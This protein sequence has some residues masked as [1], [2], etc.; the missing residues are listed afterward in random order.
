LPMT[1]PS[2]LGQSPINKYFV[3]IF[4]THYSILLHLVELFIQV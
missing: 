2:R 4:I 1:P 3:H